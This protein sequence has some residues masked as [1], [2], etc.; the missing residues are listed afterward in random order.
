[1]INMLFKVQ[2]TI[3]DYPYVSAFTDF[4]TLTPAIVISSIGGHGQC[5]TCI[6]KNFSRLSY[7][8]LHTIQ[9]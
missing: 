7:S 1:M 4:P 8:L 6:T 9:A 2:K 5:L 3:K